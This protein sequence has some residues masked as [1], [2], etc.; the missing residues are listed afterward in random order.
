MSPFPSYDLALDV[1][2]STVRAAT[3]TS[4]WVEQ[5]ALGETTP[6]LRQ[7]VVVNPEATVRMLKSV[8]RRARPSRFA[9]PRVLACAPT[10][11]S[12]LERAALTRCLLQSGAS[13][14]I[15][16]P[17]P[18]AAA[19]GARVDIASKYS[20]LI[21]DLGEGVT[22]CALIHDGKVAHSRAVRIGCADLRAQVQ[23]WAIDHL[24]R[25]VS[26]KEADDLLHEKGIANGLR[27]VVEAPLLQ[28][29]GAVKAIIHDLPPT[30]GAEVIEDGIFITGGGAMLPGMS[31][32]IEDATGIHTTVVPNPL[33][34]VVQGA[35]AMLPLASTLRLWRNST[36][37]AGAAKA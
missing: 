19:V 27:S 32:L 25:P 34:S 36:D 21:V 11:A 28:I 23:D 14:V 4:R 26:E 37:G 24:Q 2:T 10:D 9:R 15:V 29:V 17:E 16:V 22:D 12:V 33:G 18:L 8:F 13:S 3:L 35:R 1:G 20:K 5:R 6:A 30:S 7:G 31:S